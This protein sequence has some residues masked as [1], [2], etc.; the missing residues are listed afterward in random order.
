MSNDGASKTSVALMKRIGIRTADGPSGAG[1]R[2][3]AASTTFAVA[4]RGW[5]SSSTWA[6][7]K[8]KC[9]LTRAGAPELS[10]FGAV[11]D[12][13]VEEERRVVAVAPEAV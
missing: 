13:R 7:N 8:V 3:R 6:G 4:L 1:R 5:T 11:V 9:A 2:A 12:V 10:I